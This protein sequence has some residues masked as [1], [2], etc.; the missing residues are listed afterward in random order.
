MVCVLQEKK[1]QSTNSESS[2][3]SPHSCHELLGHAEDKE[4][5]EVDNKL[6]F[7]CFY[8]GL[9]ALHVYF[10]FPSADKQTQHFVKHIRP[11]LT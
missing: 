8:H 5:K 4:G 10:T 3:E 11:V 9:S 6:F 1:C 7:L 2:R